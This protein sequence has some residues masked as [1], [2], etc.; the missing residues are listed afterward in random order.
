MN[1]D[2]R[3][4]RLFADGLVDLVPPRAPGRLA[5]T[6]TAET[7]RTR[8]RPR[9]LAVIKEPPMRLSSSLAVGSP[10]AR[11]AAILAATLLIAAALTGAGI[12]GARL[13]A[14]DGTIVVDQSGGG[15]F[16]TITE[17]VA[18]AQDGDTIL[19][20]PG[21]YL[22]SV[23]VIGK[24]LVITG[25][26]DRDEIIVEATM[27]TDPEDP[28]EAFN[29]AFHL[30]DTD[31]TLSNL[32]VIGQ[33]EGTAI[34]VVG[35]SSPT[36]DGLIVRLLGQWTGAHVPIW[37]DT[38]TSGVL[39]D[40]IVEGFIIIS[41]TIGVTIEG[42]ELPATCLT[43]WD[44]GA[45]ATIVDNVIH[46]CPYE[47]AIQLDAGSAEI[48]GND[49]WVEEAPPGPHS[50]YSRNRTAIA[51]GGAD[52]PVTIGDNDVHDSVIGISVGSAVATI[53]EGNRITG[54]DTG[55][56]VSGDSVL[57]GNTISGGRLGVG[58]GPGSPTLDA[59][60][61]SDNDRGLFIS[62]VA[63]PTLTGNTICDNVTNVALAN[64]ATMPDTAGNEVCEDAPAG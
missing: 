26:G 60:T 32:T 44:A 23:P 14:A 12:A 3:F 49:I 56:T 53:I 63:S 16:S 6:I 33:E 8:P 21:R 31:S 11:I 24:T 30:L 48:T 62:A 59:N 42:N 40:S 64:G 50:S 5:T 27:S 57:V 28:D 61:I 43:L 36:L 47:F 1:D 7:A 9:W 2:A 37:W 22:E 52:G 38:D 39:R 45:R 54:N 35:T 29:W 19:V 34:S 15:D 51:L 18:A 13:L 10:T 41:S 4:E 55:M 17:A 46:G 58:L 20:R 25:D